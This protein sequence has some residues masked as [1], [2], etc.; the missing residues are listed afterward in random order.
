MKIPLINGHGM[1]IE[2]Q[3]T[4]EDMRQILSCIHIA[5][6]CPDEIHLFLGH[7]R[8]E[9]LL[10]ALIEGYVAKVG[11]EVYESQFAREEL[12]NDVAELLVMQV[13]KMIE[14]GFINKSD[15]KKMVERVLRPGVFSNTFL[16][17]IVE[18]INS[19]SL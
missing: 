2:L 1:K 7:P 8:F 16:D 10:D 17:R 15:A 6:F 14:G 13:S 4:D 11:V 12:P 19:E 18:M 3:A 9:L 5:K